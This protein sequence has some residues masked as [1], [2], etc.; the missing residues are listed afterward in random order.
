MFFN[1]ITT[2]PPQFQTSSSHVNICITAKTV[3][4]CRAEEMLRKKWLEQ[5]EI[6]RVQQQHHVV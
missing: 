3:M 4:T 6:R 1:N 5:G 2:I